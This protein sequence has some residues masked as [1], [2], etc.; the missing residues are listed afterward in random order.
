M[1]VL[2]TANLGRSHG[3]VSGSIRY[4]VF[5]TLGASVVSQTNTGV[6]EVGSET[7]IYGVELN[8][9]TQFSGTILWSVLNKPVYAAEEIKIDQKLSR[10]IHTGRWEIEQA[11]KQMV[12]YQ[13]DN[14]TEIARFDLFDRNGARSIEEIFE[15]RLVGTGSI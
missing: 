10:Y 1:K 5:D 15:R 6:Y 3:G 12:F 14:T 2:Q 7:G 13:D 8:L 4:Q 9:S 11:E